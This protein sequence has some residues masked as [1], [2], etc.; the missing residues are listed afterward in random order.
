MK[1]REAAIRL[2]LFAIL[3]ATVLFAVPVNAVEVTPEVIYY[4]SCGDGVEWTLDSVGNLVISG[5]GAIEFG[6]IFTIH[7][8]YKVDVQNWIGSPWTH[9]PSGKV[10]TVEIGDGVTSIPYRAFNGLDDLESVQMADSVTSIGLE[11]F[12]ATK[13]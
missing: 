6:D 1:I 13:L 3:L 8:L 10:V 9:L 12:I 5:K 2:T 4:G 7:G 11:A